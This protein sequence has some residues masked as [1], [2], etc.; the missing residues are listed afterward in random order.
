[1]IPG[2]RRGTLETPLREHREKENRG[3]QRLERKERGLAT[4]RKSRALRPLRRGPL[5]FSAKSKRGT[6]R[7]SLPEG[8]RGGKEKE[9]T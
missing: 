6:K 3:G 9:S 1:V 7:G 5:N 4:R 8:L 2:K